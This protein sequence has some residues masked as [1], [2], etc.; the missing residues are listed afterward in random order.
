VKIVV[1]VPRPGDADIV[2]QVAIRPEQPAAVV[3]RAR[4]IEMDNLARGM[5]SGIGTT[6][7]GH[8]NRVIGNLVESLFETLLHTEAG[9]LT[10][11]PVVRGAVVLNTKR[12][13][14]VITRSAR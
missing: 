10:L 1:N 14:H 8:L 11:P 6:S 5:H 12:N 7:T 2:R 9:V 3:A 4:R 13:A